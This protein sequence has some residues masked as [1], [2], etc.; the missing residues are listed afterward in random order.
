[1]RFCA[2]GFSTSVR[3]WY[4]GSRFLLVES[5]IKCPDKVKDQ[6]KVE[7]SW[8]CFFLF[9][10]AQKRL[11]RSIKVVKKKQSR[12]TSRPS[13]RQTKK[14]TSRSKKREGSSSP[15]PPPRSRKA[16]AK[17]DKK[18]TK[19]RRLSSSSRSFS[20]RSPSPENKSTRKGSIKIAARGRGRCSID[21]SRSSSPVQRSHSNKTSGRRDPKLNAKFALCQKLLDEIMI[22]ED[23]WP[24]LEPVDLAEVIM[25]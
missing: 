21:S 17:T 5:S 24:F 20:S 3:E 9:L 2:T 1:M 15:S 22:H 8:M 13:S 12:S 16:S 25:S 23:G 6:E 7:V 11:Q 4:S 18:P 19:R 10:A 14:N